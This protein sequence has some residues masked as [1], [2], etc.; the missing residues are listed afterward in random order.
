M[1]H[2]FTFWTINRYAATIVISA[3]KYAGGGWT[4]PKCT[5]KGRNGM[6]RPRVT[7]YIDVNISGWLGLLSMKGI[8]PVRMIWIT[9]VCVH[10]DS[11]NQPVWK[12]DSGAWKIQSNTP[13]VIKSKSEL[14]G[15][16][17]IMNF[18]M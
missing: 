7:I 1:N 14:T 10:S 16:R 15:P 8:F 2:F 11:R 4:N 6:T 17:V 5:P 13:K 18:L 3:I 12:N 9:S